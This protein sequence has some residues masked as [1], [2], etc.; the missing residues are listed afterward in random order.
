MALPLEGDRKP[1]PVVKTQFEENTG[2]ISPDGRWVAYASSDSGRSELYV[3]AF[4]GAGARPKGRWQVSNGGA[5]DVR[6]RGDGKELYYQT[7]DGKMMAAAIDAGPQD[8]RAETP[9]VL[10]SANFRSGGLREF[11]VTP[12]GQRFL[13]ILNSRTGSNT[14]RLTV[15]SN[16]QAA[17]RK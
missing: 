14:D 9:R 5:Y 11:D 3:Q 17:L 7:Q 6:W 10:F 15:V 4:P 16:W 1:I 8:I 13:L 12:D 2:A